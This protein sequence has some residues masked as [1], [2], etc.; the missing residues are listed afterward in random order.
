MSHGRGGPR[1][2]VIHAVPGAIDPIGEAFAA[3]WPE[4]RTDNLLE[5]SLST[6]L[7]EAGTETTVI[8]ERIADLAAYVTKAGAEAILYSCSAFGTSIDRVKQSSSLPV[9]KPNE[10][11]IDEALD[12]GPRIGVVA[13]FAPTLESMRPE[14][15]DQAHQ[16]EIDLRLEECFVPNAMEALNSGEA[17]RHDTLIAEAAATLDGCDAIVLAQFTMAR[18]RPAVEAATTTSVLT[19][20]GSAVARLKHI[21]QTR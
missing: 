15:K 2:A 8:Q 6:D 1:V 11:M 10:A 20:P 14:F 17:E 4:A 21:W 18:A 9:L 5:E 16:R 3:V 19:S 13:T 12:L 7:A